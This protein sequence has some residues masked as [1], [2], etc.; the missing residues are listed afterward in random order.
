[1]H[2]LVIV[3]FAVMKCM[4]LALGCLLYQAAESDS[5]PKV[6]TWLGGK[7]LLRM[8]SSYVRSLDFEEGSHE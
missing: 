8:F 6:C 2:V 5:S 7:V 1:M 4:Y 3:I